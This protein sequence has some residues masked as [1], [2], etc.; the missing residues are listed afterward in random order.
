MN[1][2]L[3]TLEL[4][5]IDKMDYEEFNQRKGQLEQHLDEGDSSSIRDA[6]SELQ[7]ALL[8]SGDD[9]EL[10]EVMYNWNPPVKI[11]SSPH[12]ATIFH[13]LVDLTKYDDVES[14]DESYEIRMYAT[15]LLAYSDLNCEKTL[16]E[17]VTGGHAS[18]DTIVP[19][20]MGLVAREC[21][22]Y[23]DVLFESLFGDN[24]TPDS[25]EFALVEKDDNIFIALGKLHD[26]RIFDILAEY[27]AHEELDWMAEDILLKI[28]NDLSNNIL[29]NQK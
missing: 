28:D 9:H 4:E 18:S 27:V 22:E 5:V 20:T 15:E 8:D 7:W 24:P 23:C 6:L 19:A 14:V 13:H 2:C 21:R 25:I 26:Q 17:M 16:L 1:P 10:D 3:S 29:N 12:L 11:K